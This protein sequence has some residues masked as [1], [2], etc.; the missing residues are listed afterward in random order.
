MLAIAIFA[1][2]CA[3]GSRTLATSWPGLTTDGE[4]IYLASGLHVYA[5]NAANGS[6][7]WRFPVEPDNKLSFYASPTLGED[8]QLIVGGYNNILYSI[9]T[10]SGQSINWTFEEARNRYIGSSLVTDELIL[11][12]SADRNLYALDWNGVQQWNFTTQEAQWSQPAT[13][14]E[15]VFLTSLDHYL[16]AINLENGDEVWKVDMGGA[17]VGT[18]LVANGVVYVGS[19]A[20]TLTA[21]DAQTGE[22]QWTFPTTDWVWASPVLDNGVLYFG[23]IDGTFYAVNAEAGDEAWKYTADGGVFGSPLV[24]NGK[25]YFGTDKGNLY[26]FNTESEQLWS[27]NIVGKIFTSP[28]IVNNLIIVALME[29]DKLLIAYDENKV[30]RWN[31]TPGE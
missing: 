11:A 20:K 17:V 25:I 21:L 9:D 2:A 30:E 16:Y 4:T 29:S 27:I 1:T 3:G 14:G 5:I 15:T 18:P 8:G 6:Q 19:F 28:I 23:S 26:A 7:T 31:Y 22:V 12:P 24:T 10:E 13:D